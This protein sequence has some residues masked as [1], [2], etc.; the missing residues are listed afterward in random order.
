MRLAQAIAA[1]RSWRRRRRSASTPS[2]RSPAPCPSASPS[3][4]HRHDRRL[5]RLRQRRPQGDALRIDQ[6]TGRDGRF[7]TTHVR[8]TPPAPQCCRPT[9]QPDERGAERRRRGRHRRQGARA[10]TGRGRQDRHDPVLPRRLV[11]RLTGWYSAAMW[12]GN[13]DYT[14][15]NNMTAAAA[16]EH[17][18]GHDGQDPRRPAAALD[19]GVERRRRRSPRRTRARHARPRRDRPRRLTPD[20]LVIAAT[21]ALMRSRLVLPSSDPLGPSCSRPMP[22]S[23][24]TGAAWSTSATRRACAPPR[25]STP[26]ASPGPG[27]D[28]RAGIA[29]PPRRPAVQ[30][31]WHPRNSARQPPGI[32]ERFAFAMT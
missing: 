24:R 7:S 9:S 25:A 11:R 17:L 22:C 31:P 18:A 13:D 19:P 30:P 23:R 16:G 20:A 14:S 2:S 26:S 10:R 27:P 32:E 4:R 8:D 15:T 29:S 28:R 5:R 21:G 12:L 3:Q 6:I 1:T